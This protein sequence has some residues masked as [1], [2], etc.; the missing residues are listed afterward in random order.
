MG[1]S[2]DNFSDKSLIIYLYFFGFFSFFLENLKNEKVAISQLLKL[3]WKYKGTLFPSTL[4]LI[5]QKRFLELTIYLIRPSLC[6]L[7]HF[8]KRLP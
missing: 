4:K 1:A 7:I 2:K 6:C 3:K 5:F 8:S